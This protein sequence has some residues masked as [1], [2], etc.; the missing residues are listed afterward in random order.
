[1]EA[2]TLICLPNDFGGWSSEVMGS[3]FKGIHINDRTI[4]TFTFSNST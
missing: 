4:I 3:R 1:M 2:F